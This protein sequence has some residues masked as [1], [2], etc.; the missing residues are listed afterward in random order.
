MFGPASEHGHET[1]TQPQIRPQPSLPRTIEIR[2]W[3]LRPTQLS[4]GSATSFDRNTHAAGRIALGCD[5]GVLRHSGIVIAIGI[6]GGLPFAFMAAR[7]AGSMLWGVKAEQR[8]AIGDDRT[9]EG[10]LAGHASDAPALT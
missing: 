10:R 2:G 3:A 1:Q 6:I 8:A 9:R 5:N 7:M 4:R